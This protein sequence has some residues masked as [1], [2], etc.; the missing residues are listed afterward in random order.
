M[1]I[2]SDALPAHDGEFVLESRRLFELRT[3]FGK[4][5][6]LAVS[7][8][9]DISFPISALVSNAHAP[10]TRHMVCLKIVMRFL[11]GT[12]K[13]GTLY[14]RSFPSDKEGLHACADSHW[15]WC[16]TTMK[17]TIGYT[18]VINGSPIR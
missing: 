12:R 18:I 3:F 10:K 14:P 17:S 8:R 6:Y 13:M 1:P 11:A 15:A 4:L 5:L 7:S 16:K 2:D 9:H